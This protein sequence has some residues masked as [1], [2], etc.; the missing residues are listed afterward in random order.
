MVSDDG[1]D[2]GMTV[3]PAATVIG[4][5]FA[6]SLAA[7]D[8]HAEDDGVYGCDAKFP[9]PQGSEKM[10]MVRVPSSTIRNKSLVTTIPLFLITLDK[11]GEGIARW[12]IARSAAVINKPDQVFGG[13]NSVFHKPAIRIVDPAWKRHQYRSGGRGTTSFSS[14]ISPTFCALELFWGF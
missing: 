11:L 8:F 12:S 13:E 5:G 10:V 6:K 3:A 9:P 7:L 1:R 4:G 14:P 2:D